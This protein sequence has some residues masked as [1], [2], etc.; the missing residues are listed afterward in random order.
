[1]TYEK[2]DQSVRALNICNVV[3][4]TEQFEDAL[5][6]LNIEALHEELRVLRPGQIVTK[7]SMPDITDIPE[8]CHGGLNI[9]IPILFDDGAEWMLRLSGYM[10]DHP[11]FEVLECVK[12]SEVATMV[13]LQSVSGLIPRVHG[14]GSGKLSKSGGESRCLGCSQVTRLMSS[15][16]G[17]VY[18]SSQI[19]NQASRVMIYFVSRTVNPK[20]RSGNLSKGTP[21]I[22][23]NLPVCSS[24]PSVVCGLGAL[25]VQKKSQSVHVSIY[26]LSARPLR[27]TFQVLSRLCEIATFITSIKCLIIQERVW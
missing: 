19:S 25:Q 26:T 6:D 5:Q 4:L 3:S 17:D 27:H 21:S 13:A 20:R 9:H 22:P 10:R 11:P 14:W 24:I 23:S 18:T 8:E 2:W 15:Q 16:T 7:I 1:M 12:H